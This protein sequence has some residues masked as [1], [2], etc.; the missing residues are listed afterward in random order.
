MA[1]TV[2][3]YNQQFECCKH[4]DGRAEVARFCP[5]PLVNMLKLVVPISTSMV[6]EQ[7]PNP[8]FSQGPRAEDTGLGTVSGLSLPIDPLLPF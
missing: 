6:I 4:L 8:A 7:V 2:G 1:I 5:S 3:S